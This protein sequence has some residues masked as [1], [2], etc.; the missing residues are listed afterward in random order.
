[1]KRYTLDILED[2]DFNAYINLPEELLRETGWM[3][4][5]VLEYE[6]DLDGNIIFCLLYTSDAADDL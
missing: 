5:D 3:A 2:D 1:M 4:G 6:E